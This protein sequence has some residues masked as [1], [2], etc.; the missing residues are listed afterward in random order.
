MVTFRLIERSDEKLVYRYFP[1]GK[2]EHGFGIIEVDRIAGRIDVKELAPD[3]M[4]RKHTVEEQLRIR[5]AIVNMRRTE[6][7]PE[8][9]EEEFPIPTEDKIST[10]F[11]DHA[12]QKIVEAYNRGDILEEGQAVW[13]M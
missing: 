13:E 11:A 5:N 10:I 7:L 12:I 4:L 6:Q 8:L 3:D 2:A 9:T 1:L